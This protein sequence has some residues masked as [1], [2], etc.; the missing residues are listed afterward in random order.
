MNSLT[1]TGYGHC[2]GDMALGRRLGRWR[3]LSRKVANASDYGCEVNGSLSES[4]EGDNDRVFDGFCPIG[5]C[6]DGRNR[7]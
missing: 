7:H 4:V 6:L 5:L 1:A 2:L 3:A